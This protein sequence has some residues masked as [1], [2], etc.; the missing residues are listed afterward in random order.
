MDSVKQTV[1]GLVPRWCRS[2]VWKLRL[3]GFAVYCPCCGSHFRK[4]V[5]T[6]VQARP[7]ARC[8]RCNS[9][10]RHRLLWLYLQNRTG[11]FSDGLK[12]L[13]VAPEPFFQK[14]FK[15]MPN[16]DYTSADIES[17]LAMVKMDIMDI[18]YEDGLFDVILCYHVLEHVADDRRAMREFLR[19]LKPGGWA[20]LQ[21]P[22][23]HT[24]EETF[25]DPTVTSPEERE[26]VFG[27]SDHVR[28]YGRDYKERL[29]EAGWRVTV[30]G[31]VRELEPA[32]IKK[33]GLAT[34]QDI[35]LCSKPPCRER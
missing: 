23:D 20:I 33:Y 25:E 15:A 31:Y 2:A 8:P 19:V 12:V 29:E 11:F 21:V 16:L 22:M 9:V 3:F 35:Y 28:V 5:P 30:D 32:M 27:Q 17:P 10:E 14:T 13:H 18:P 7:N 24:R 4:F 26:R 1:G 6:G 34:D